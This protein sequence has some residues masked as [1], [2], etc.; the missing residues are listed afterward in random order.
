VIVP[1]SLAQLLDDQII[2]T[3]PRRLGGAGFLLPGRSP[4]R[5]RNPSG[6]ADS[7]R[8]H[9]LPARAA[10]NTAMMQNLDDLPPIVIADLFGVHPATAHRWAQ[11]ATSSWADYLSADQDISS[12]P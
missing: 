2:A 4:G 8:H 5:S 9:G 10:R 7:L 3:A 6:L 1:P 12:F 11:L